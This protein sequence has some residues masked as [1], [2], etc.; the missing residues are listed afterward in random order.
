MGEF[1]EAWRSGQVVRK[2]T[3]ENIR[4]ENIAEHTWGVVLLLIIAWPNAPARVIKMAHVHDNGERATGDM[5]GPTK[6]ANPTLGSEMDRL[7]R[8]HIMDT[9]PKHLCDEYSAMSETDWAVIEFFDRAEFCVS[10][11]RERRLGNTYAMEYFNRS[12]DKMVATYQE[13][14][15]NFEAK[16]PQLAAGMQAL[17]KELRQEK[18]YLDHL[19][20]S[21]P[22]R[23]RGD[24]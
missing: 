18:W 13:H 14:S 15:E 24:H 21:V 19:S 22:V 16:D 12:F 9:L 7:E 11:S 10:M 5:P 3:M 6:W 20:P 17:Y 8:Q 4:A 2:H 1:I 23:L